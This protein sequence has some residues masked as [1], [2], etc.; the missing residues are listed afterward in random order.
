MAGAVLNENG[1]DTA[2]Q[3]VGEGTGE[4]A[5]RTRRAAEEWRVTIVANPPVARALYTLPLDAEIPP[6]YFQPVAAII[7][8]VMKLKTP[9]SRAA[10]RR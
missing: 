10:P 1:T 6:E 7:A 4:L 8:Y 2:P 5:G 3:F 9:G